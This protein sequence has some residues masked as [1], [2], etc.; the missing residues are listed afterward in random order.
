MA[1]RASSAEAARQSSAVGAAS[2]GDRD[3]VGAAGLANRV[4]VGG[5]RLIAVWTAV[6]FLFVRTSRSGVALCIEGQNARAGPAS[7]APLP[8]HACTTELRPRRGTQLM[9]RWY[10]Y[11]SATWRVRSATVAEAENVWPL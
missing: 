9:V 7:R 5:G 10:R 8:G 11:E 2:R 1:A 4:R 6:R 3:V